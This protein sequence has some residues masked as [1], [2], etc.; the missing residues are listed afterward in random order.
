MLQN[1]NQKLN[2]KAESNKIYIAVSRNHTFFKFLF[3]ILK[4]E[5]IKKN[6]DCIISVAWFIYICTG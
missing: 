4:S 6:T 5:L 2:R 1:S 3:I